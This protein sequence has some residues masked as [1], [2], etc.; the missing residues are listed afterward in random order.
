[1]KSEV[2]WYYHRLC[3]TGGYMGCYS[4]ACIFIRKKQLKDGPYALTTRGVSGCRKNYGNQLYKNASLLDG[5]QADHYS[6]L[7]FIRANLHHPIWSGWC[8]TRRYLKQVWPHK[9]LNYAASISPSTCTTPRSL[10]C[11]A[12]SAA[13]S[14]AEPSYAT[15]PF[16]NTTARSTIES[17]DSA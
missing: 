13:N 4:R 3:L 6:C 14:L 17:T 11:K 12:S 1:M 9:N 8:T 2:V 5:D 10:A 7:H 15:S 16:T